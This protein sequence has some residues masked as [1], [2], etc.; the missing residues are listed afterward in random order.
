MRRRFVLPPSRSF[1]WTWR[2]SKGKRLI[3]IC[4]WN[5]EIGTRFRG[6]LWRRYAD[7]LQKAIVKTFELTDVPVRAGRFVARKNWIVCGSDG[8]SSFEVLGERV[9]KL[10]GDAQ[11]FNYGFTTTTR[12]RRSHP[13]KHIRIIFELSSCTQPTHSFSLPQMI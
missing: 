8:Q 2:G 13:S 3:W 7:G 4:G 9:W 6:D 1:G 10:M 5:L 11:I 12:A